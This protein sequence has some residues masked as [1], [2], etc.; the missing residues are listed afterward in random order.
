M[1]Y[2]VDRAIH[3][4]N[5]CP[6]DSANFGFPNTYPVDSDLSSGECYPGLNNLGGLV[7]IVSSL[8]FVFFLK[9]KGDLAFVVMTQSIQ[10][11]TITRKMLVIKH[12]LVPTL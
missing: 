11:C 12:M 2:L 5:L 1:I 8:I 3:W 6:L 10:L 9:G 7:V 4:I